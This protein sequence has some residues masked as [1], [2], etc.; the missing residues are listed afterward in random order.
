[1][2]Q[3]EIVKALLVLGANANARNKKNDTARHLAA[4]LTNTKQ[5][6]DIVRALAICGAMRCA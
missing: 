4:K 5:R 6:V 1:L 2:G 3:L